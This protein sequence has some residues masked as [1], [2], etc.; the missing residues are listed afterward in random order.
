MKEE[1]TDAAHSRESV[2]QGGESQEWTP[3]LLL[4]E[5]EQ[6]GMT[7]REIADKY[8]IER[9]TVSWR[10]HDARNGK[11]S[12]ASLMEQIANPLDG[13]EA[14]PAYDELDMERWKTGL[15][16]LPE[17]YTVAV[18][19]DKHM[20]DMDMH[21]FE[22]HVRIM[23]DIK[24]N[25]YT[26]GSDGHDFRTISRF[27]GN[28]REL[29]EDAWYGA[30]KQFIDCHKAI[31]HVLAESALKPLKIGNHDIRW[32]LFLMQQSPKFKRIAAQDYVRVIRESGCLWLGWDFDTIELETVVISH[33]ERHG[34][35]AA[36][37]AGD[38]IAW[39]KDYIQ[40]H[41]H[42]FSSYTKT[43]K[44]GVRQAHTTGCL[45]NN[46]PLYERVKGKSKKK[47]WQH[48]FTLLTVDK[49]NMTTEFEPIVFTSNYGASFRGKWYQVKRQVY[50]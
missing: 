8:G 19:T 16:A 29:S 11:D 37:R 48:G 14:I 43:T 4:K 46:P 36:R 20:P 3:Q 5:Y 22:L 45:C 25:I 32:I 18:A 23:D 21:A 33:G 38:D 39:I 35:N 17:K 49:V 41:V 7:Y 34:V 26:A 31:D 9:E 50:R 12:I 10:I 6:N 47:S 40:G 28:V 30:D 15:A 42:Y 44:H 13:Y 2:E 1:G 24:P 27:P